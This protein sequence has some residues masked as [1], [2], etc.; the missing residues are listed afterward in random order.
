[1]QL[2]DDTY[3]NEEYA[4]YHRMTFMDPPARIIKIPE[5]IGSE[6]RR[7]VLDT[8][9]LVWV[10]PS[11]AG[12][13]GRAAVERLL[14]DRG[15]PSRSRTSKGKLSRLN[16]GQRIERFG[17]VH[18][19]LAEKLTAI[20]WIGNVGSHSADMTSETILDGLDVLS[21]VLDE[22]YLNRKQRVARVAKR[23]TTRR[24]RPG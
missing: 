21:Y 11:A 17:K 4:R 13:R 2:V 5:G 3:T 22:I 24:G 23:L 7:F 20:R 18:P 15:I 1:V 19:D 12:N 14:T 6:L 10:D 8:C 16:L 9:R